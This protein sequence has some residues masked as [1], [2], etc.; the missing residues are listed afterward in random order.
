VDEPFRLQIVDSG[1]L[2]G[3]IDFVGNFGQDF[4]LPGFETD[5]AA[6]F[7]LY[8]GPNSDLD[9]A[10]NSAPNSEHR[11]DLKPDFDS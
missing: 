7:D 1:N 11:F 9:S 8:S 5:F 2:G 4:A 3:E 6:D 10:P